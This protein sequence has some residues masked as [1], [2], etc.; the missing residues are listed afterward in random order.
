MRKWHPEKQH[1]GMGYRIMCA[2]CSKRFPNQRELEEHQA[3]THPEFWAVTSI[4]KQARYKHT[5]CTICGKQFTQKNLLQKHMHTH[6][7]RGAAPTGT[8]PP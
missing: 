7:G 8:I 1:G 3:A 5:T 4:E 6:T 2:L